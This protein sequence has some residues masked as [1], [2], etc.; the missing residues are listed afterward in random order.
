M[1]YDLWMKVQNFHEAH[2]QL[3]GSSWEEFSMYCSSYLKCALS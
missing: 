3:S 1:N 2:S